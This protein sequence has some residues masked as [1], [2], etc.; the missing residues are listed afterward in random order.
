MEHIES[1]SWKEKQKEHLKN[2]LLKNALELFDQN[3]LA[4]TS[5]DDIVKRTG[6]AKGTFYLYFKSKSDVI[7]QW[8]DMVVTGLE[9]KIM[10]ELENHSSNPE[11]ALAYSVKAIIDFIKENLQAYNII[12]GNKL[13]SEYSEYIH[14][15]NKVTVS[16]FEKNIR[17]GMLQGSFKDVDAKLY[18][19]ALYGI[20]TALAG[21]DEINNEE[22]AKTA[23]NVFFYGI[24][25]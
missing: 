18:A 12:F 19:I 15:I 21:S 23:L 10:K 1:V 6:V 5:V 7:S 24:R 13:D 4:Q 9:N 16:L 25:K 20:I 3:G 14:R 22:S 11:D 17:L 2:T 8:M